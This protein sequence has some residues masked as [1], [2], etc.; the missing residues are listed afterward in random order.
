M[1]G[2]HSVLFERSRVGSV[3]QLGGQLGKFSA[4]ADE[5]R[6]GKERKNERTDD[7]PKTS[8]RHCVK[9]HKINRRVP[10]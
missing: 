5:V 7:L 3:G 2:T 6:W 4:K 1:D 8:D 10:G 9:R